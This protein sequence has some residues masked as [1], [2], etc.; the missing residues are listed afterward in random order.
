MKIIKLLGGCF[1][2]A[3]TLL[4]C[5]KENKVNNQQLNTADNNFIQI[6]ATSNA[7]YV[8]AAKVAIS[9]TTDTIISSYAQQILSAHS[10]AQ[11]DLKIMGKLVGFTVR[12]TIDESHA[13]II[14]HLDSLAGRMFDSAYIH[15]ELSAHQETIQFCTKE[16]NDGQQLNVTGYANN[17]FQNVQ[18]QKQRADSIAIGF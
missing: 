9:K 18:L 11:D 17:L 4:A 6:A 2:A 8:L 14:T 5:K 16:L 12:D 10:A 3:V 7:A 1:F 15:N 13:A